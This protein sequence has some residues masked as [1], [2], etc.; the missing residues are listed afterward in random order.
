MLP[1]GLMIVRFSRDPGEDPQNANEIA[2]KRNYSAEEKERWLSQVKFLYDI[3]ENGDMVFP[4]DACHLGQ[5]AYWFFYAAELLEKTESPRPEYKK[6]ALGFCDFILSRQ[7]E[8]GSYGK[9]WDREG[10]TFQDS[11]TVGCFFIDP[12]LKAFAITRDEQYLRSA[13]KA[14]DFYYSSLEENGFT[15]AG[16]LDTYCIDKESSSPLLSTALNLY[17]ITGDKKYAERAETI[18]W[19]LSS[20]MMH[21]SVKYESD[22]VLGRLGMDTFGLTVVSTGHQAVDVYALH[23]VCSFFR[24]AKITGNEEW[25][26]RALVFFHGAS[27]FIS[28]GTLC[29][30][31]R[32]RPA[33]T[34]DEALLHT[35]WTRPDVE[36]FMPN[37]AI[38]TWFTAFRLEVFRG[39]E[40]WSMLDDSLLNRFPI[41]PY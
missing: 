39:L 17:G 38:I 2:A 9:S 10:N 36:H 31:D 16:A 8:N 1:N 22:T 37:D 5:A 29:V 28:D 13:V 30:M 3:K 23:D 12:V 4:I 25:K 32:I 20:W 27:R 19:Y 18:A 7:K 14:F 26:E 40:D 11:G 6:A 35:R 33:G 34:Q 21:Y 15:T 41:E 24:L